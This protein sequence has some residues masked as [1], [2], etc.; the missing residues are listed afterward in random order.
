MPPTCKV[1][2]D[3]RLEEIDAEI[4]S[5]RSIPAIGRQFALK[6]SGLY[7]HRKDHMTITRSIK[8]SRPAG[9]AATV[10]HL[11]NLDQQLA[12]AQVMAIRRG[13]AQAVV[14]ALAQRV[15]LALEISNL[16]DEIKP[17]AKDNH[18]HFHLKPEEAANVARALI[19]HEELTGGKVIDGKAKQ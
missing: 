13:A 7:R 14:A 18:V 17:R 12:E 19:R 9:I 16:R 15:K 4:A 11:L 1:C 6:E 5:G 10:E 2:T 3:P 8:T